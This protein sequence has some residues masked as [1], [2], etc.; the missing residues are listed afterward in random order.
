MKLGL[1]Y[2]A[3]VVARLASAALVLGLDPTPSVFG[4]LTL[5][6]WIRARQR[7]KR[8]HKQRPDFAQSRL[9]RSA[10]PEHSRLG[11][12]RPSLHKAPGLANP[13]GVQ[14]DSRL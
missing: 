2:S 5:A 1:I 6:Q 8:S 14:N 4:E 3:P 7:A 9:R 10:A 11:A 13:A 12:G